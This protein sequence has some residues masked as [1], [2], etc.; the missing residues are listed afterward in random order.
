MLNPDSVLL[1][2]H[3]EMVLSIAVYFLQIV[4]SFQYSYLILILHF[5]IKYSFAQSKCFQVT[6]FS[7]R[8]LLLIMLFNWPLPTE[9]LRELP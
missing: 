3:S 7:I 6:L 8:G 4:T 5:I 2:A 9:S 1:F